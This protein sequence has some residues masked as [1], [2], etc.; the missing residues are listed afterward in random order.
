MTVRSITR[1]LYD[2]AEAGWEHGD[3]ASREDED[4]GQVGPVAERR[5]ER[6]DRQIH[7]LAIEAIIGKYRLTGDAATELR[8]HPRLE[9]ILSSALVGDWATVESALTN[10]IAVSTGERRCRAARAGTIHGRHC[11]YGNIH[12]SEEPAHWMCEGFKPVE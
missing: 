3:A 11:W 5:V 7:V 10:A 6:L 2:I 1:K 4:Y 9:I 8:T 12:A